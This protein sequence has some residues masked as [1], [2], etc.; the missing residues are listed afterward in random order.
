M[1]PTPEQPRFMSYIKSRRT[2][3]KIHQA[4]GHAINSIVGNARSYDHDYEL[5]WGDPGYD[6]DRQYR[7]TSDCAILEWV[8]DEWMTLHE[9]EKNS[10]YADRP[11]RSETK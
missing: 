3:F 2:Q 5:S 8:N 10:N 1:P 4:V 6:W 9:V 11:W 7:F